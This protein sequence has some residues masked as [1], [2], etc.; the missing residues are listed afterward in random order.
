[1][2]EKALTGSRRYWGLVFFL[3]IVLGI[4]A[5]CYFFTQAQEG[6]HIVGV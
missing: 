6:L 1:M 2:L 4:G 3:L 5:A